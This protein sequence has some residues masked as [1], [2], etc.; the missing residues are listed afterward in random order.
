MKIQSRSHHPLYKVWYNMVHR[1]T[2]P[3]CCSWEDYGKRGIKTCD[4][5]INSFEA[6]I[7][8]MG[9][10]PHGMT[11]ERINNNGDYEPGNCKW[12]TWTEQA[13][14]RRNRSRYSNSATWVRI[15]H[16]GQTLVEF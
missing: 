11:L 14:N 2:T 15:S 7:E 8:D 13:R 10:K 12:A 16:A 4:R 3:S 5:W 6:F 1:T 9:E